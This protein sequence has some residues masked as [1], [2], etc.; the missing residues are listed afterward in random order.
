MTRN[1]SVHVRFL[2]RTKSF[3]CPARLEYSS[4]SSG[5]RSAGGTGTPRPD[6]QCWPRLEGGDTRHCP[7]YRTTPSITSCPRLSLRSCP[8]RS[9]EGASR[10]VRFVP[11]HVS[12]DTTG[13]TLDHWR[14]CRI[15]Q[16]VAK[17]VLAHGGGGRL[18]RGD[19]TFRI[20]DAFRSCRECSRPSQKRWRDFS[21]KR[22]R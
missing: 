7:R 10:L 12:D 1:T 22:L 5:N 9:V 6:R 2:D 3:T 11:K 16:M 14:V 13:S 20:G 4:N 15:L 17:V 21:R 18:T 8:T 19:I